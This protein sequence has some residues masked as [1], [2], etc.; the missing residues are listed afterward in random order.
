MYMH[1]NMHMYHRLLP[2]YVKSKGKGQLLYVAHS[3]A[4]VPGISFW[5]ILQY[6]FLI[7]FWIRQVLNV[8]MAEHMF[9]QPFD[10]VS[11]DSQ[12]KSADLFGRQRQ[13]FSSIHSDVLDVDLLS[14]T[15]PDYTVRV[16]RN[17]L[18]SSALLHSK[19]TAVELLLNTTYDAQVIKL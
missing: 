9:E 14:L 15:S 3:V 11:A 17:P 1:M 5:M 16:R 19:S 13:T 4:A 18:S 12:L 10:A 7:P 2:V 8:F 6:F